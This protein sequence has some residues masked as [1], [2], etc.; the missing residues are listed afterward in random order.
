MA[1]HTAQH[2]VPETRMAVG[3]C[4]NQISANS[5]DLRMQRRAHRLV[6]GM[7]DIGFG[8]NTVPRKM[9]A[10]VGARDGTMFA[11]ASMRI[12]DHHLDKF[13]AL[14]QRQC[15]VDGAHRF[16]ASVPADHDAAAEGGDLCLAGHHQY[17]STRFES[18]VFGG[19]HIKPAQP[20]SSL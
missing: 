6:F 3:A 15:I 8:V 13:C 5:R 20:L 14:Q 4:H 2:Q 1:S 9:Q 16:A 19:G 7:A 10:D 11:I 18:N 17:R 12:D